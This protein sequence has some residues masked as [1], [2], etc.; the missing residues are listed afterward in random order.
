MKDLID[1]CDEQ[2][3]GA[4]GNLRVAFM[5]LPY[6]VLFSINIVVRSCFKFWLLELYFYIASGL[7]NIDPTLTCREFEKLSST[8]KCL[9]APDAKDAGNGAAG[10]CSWSAN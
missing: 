4:I 9:K 8:N 1:I 2:N 5:R 6:C 7:R 3:V 10:K